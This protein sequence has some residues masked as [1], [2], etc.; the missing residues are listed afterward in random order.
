[1]LLIQEM[2]KEGF[3]VGCST[4]MVKCALFE[5]NS[6]TVCL[7]NSPSMRPRAKHINVK[8]HHFRS[9]VASRALKIEKTSSDEQLADFL[10]KQSSAE[11]H[12]V[13]RMAIMGWQ[14]L[15]TAEPSAC[16]VGCPESGSWPKLQGAQS[17]QMLASQ[18]LSG[19]EPGNMLPHSPMGMVFL[20]S[21]KLP[22]RECRNT[23]QSPKW[24]RISLLDNERE[25]PL[26]K[27]SCC[28]PN[29]G[30]KCLSDGKASITSEA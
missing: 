28:V 9:M 23:Q 13:H 30:H 10:T 14:I 21:L 22:E 7:A 8:H 25:L 26:G 19:Q 11:L 6:G 3:N 12:L 17:R 29:A 18:A 24:G 1:M 20:L 16:A 5:D 4:P 15:P 27:R 2:K